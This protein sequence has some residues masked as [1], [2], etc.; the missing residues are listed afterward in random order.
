MSNVLEPRPQ[1]PLS[2]VPLLL[3]LLALADLR[4]ELQLLIDHP[5]FTELRHAL[6]AHPLAIVVLIVQPSLWRHYRREPV[7]GGSTLL[8]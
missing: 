8:G 1:R 7:K 2:L 6:L 4:T 5:T 3:L